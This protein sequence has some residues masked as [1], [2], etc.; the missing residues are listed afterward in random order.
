MKL[1]IL[2][3]MKLN[4]FCFYKTALYIAVEN[5]NEKIVKLLLSHKDIDVNIKSIFQHFFIQFQNLFK[6]CF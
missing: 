3:L 1:K 6:L 2:N 4:V 5:R